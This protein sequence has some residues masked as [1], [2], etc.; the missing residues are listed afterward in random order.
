[1]LSPT[2]IAFSPA[3]YPGEAAVFEYETSIAT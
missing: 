3:L 1:M 2:H